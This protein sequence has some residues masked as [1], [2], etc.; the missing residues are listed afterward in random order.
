VPIEKINTQRAPAAIGPYSQAVRTGDYLFFSGQIPLDPVSGNIVG[1]DAETQTRQVLK[2]I[3]AVLEAAGLAAD[4]V[5]KTTVYLADLQDF[6]AVNKVYA[7]YFGEAKPARATVQVTALPKG[8]LV[9]IEGIAYSG[10]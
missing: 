8:A 7:E 6:A 9:E 10:S 3:E 1:Q 5:L 4:R 2:N